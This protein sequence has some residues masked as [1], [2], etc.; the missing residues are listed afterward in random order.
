MMSFDL[1]LALI[2]FAFVTSIT[3]GP[4]N[5]MLLTSGVNFGFRRTLPHMLGIGL[6]F[7]F[8]VVLVGLGLGQIFAR[9]PVL[10]SVL[11]IIGAVYMLYLAWAIAHSGPIE[12]GKEIGRPMR[13]LGAA[14]FQWV[15]PKAWIMALSAISTYSQPEH[16]IASVM[17]IAGIFGAVNLPSVSVWALFGVGMRK[18]LSDPRQVRWFNRLMAFLLIASLWPIIADLLPH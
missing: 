9:F 10:Y 16:Y 4:N 6:G 11:K 12:G 13:F 15:N 2:G 5:L 7:T 18:L 17:L 14:A 1:I 8:M 3:P